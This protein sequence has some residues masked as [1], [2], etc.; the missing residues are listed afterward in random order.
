[1]GT[2]ARTPPGLDRSQIEAALRLFESMEQWKRTDRA[3]ALLADRF[4]THDPESVLLKASVLNSLYSTG[5]LAIVRMAEHMASVLEGID[6]ATVGPEVIED[7]AVLPAL[8][9]GAKP[10][11]NVSLA[12]KYAHI[13]ISE[14]RFSER[15]PGHL[16]GLVRS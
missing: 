5:V 7:L 12:S 6:T 9:A 2:P 15:P 11:H 10:R 1:M 3:L 4:P 16:A 14:E 8:D 13:F